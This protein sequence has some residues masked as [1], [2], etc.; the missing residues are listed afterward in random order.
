[1]RKNLQLRDILSFTH[2]FNILMI[3]ITH[4]FIIIDDGLAVQNERQPRNTATI[5]MNEFREMDQNKALREAAVAVG[6]FG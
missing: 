3:L 1:M 4:Y 5:K 6:I 2:F